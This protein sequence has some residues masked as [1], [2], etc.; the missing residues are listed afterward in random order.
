MT[1]SVLENCTLRLPGTGDI[2]GVSA[3]PSAPSTPFHR[4]SHSTSM[5]QTSMAHTSSAFSTS[6]SFST[7]S[8]DSS[9]GGSGS[10]FSTRSSRPLPTP[11]PRSTKSV[12]LTRSS[13]PVKDILNQ[14]GPLPPPGQKFI[15]LW[16][17]NLPAAPNQ[18]SNN[19]S[20]APTHRSRWP[21]PCD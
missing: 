16:K 20:P 9:S 4:A 7:H 12:E 3:F 17:R 14:T 1:A 19:S 18:S 10:Q 5:A 15:P 21:C 6:S 11:V 2:G 8:T 13:S